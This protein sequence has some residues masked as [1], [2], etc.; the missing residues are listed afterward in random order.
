MPSVMGDKRRHV[1]IWLRGN[2]EGVV[3]ILEPSSSVLM[4][5]AL[6]PLEIFELLK[7]AF[8]KSSWSEDV[9]SV[10]PGISCSCRN[11][12]TT[13]S[14]RCRSWHWLD[15][16]QPLSSIAQLNISFFCISLTNNYSL[17]CLTNVSPAEKEDQA[18]HFVPIQILGFSPWSVPEHHLFRNYE[19]PPLP[20]QLVLRP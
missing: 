19:Q 15:L 2:E 20:F 16:N 14:L 3:R 13:F 10:L 9:L 7:Q 1:G 5:S 11:I 8:P 4:T 17:T 18:I 6:Y 12:R